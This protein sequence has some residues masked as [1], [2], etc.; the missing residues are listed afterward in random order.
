MRPRMRESSSRHP[1]LPTACSPASARRCLSRGRGTGTGRVS[2]TAPIRFEDRGG[3]PAS[4]GAPRHARATFANASAAIAVPIRTRTDTR[5]ANAK[6]V[7]PKRRAKISRP[8]TIHRNA[9]RSPDACDRSR[10]P[11]DR[12]G[13]L[14]AS[15]PERLEHRV[16]RCR[17]TDGGHERVAQRGRTEKRQ[18]P[19]EEKRR[20]STCWR[21]RTSGK[22]WTLDADRAGSPTSGRSRSRFDDTADRL[23][24][25]L[26]DDPRMAESNAGS[27]RRSRPPGEGLRRR[28][29][30]AS[31]E[32]RM[33]TRPTIRMLPSRQVFRHLWCR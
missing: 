14:T 17:R 31:P 21:R 3:G 10:M 30:P 11:R 22:S 33:T 1:R 15:E 6:P 26:W 18:K 24:R 5:G 9:E 16:L 25:R 13:E 29:P 8:T 2:A 12:G 23:R 7:C 4:G 27:S 28:R 32:R 20:C 19:G